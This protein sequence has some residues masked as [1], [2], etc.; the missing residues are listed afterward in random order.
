[1]SSSSATFNYFYF[2][3]NF[4]LFNFNFTFKFPHEQSK[5]FPHTPSRTHA[6][7]PTNI[8]IFDTISTPLRSQRLFS[9]RTLRTSP[10]RFCNK[11]SG[12]LASC[13]R[14][15]I[16]DHHSHGRD[17][18]FVTNSFLAPLTKGQVSEA[19]GITDFPSS[20]SILQL[21]IQIATPP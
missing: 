9:R 6:L 3:Y 4:W 5:C 20:S 11:I 15:Q 19:N 8:F 12:T 2:S 10:D 13:T 14:T 16:I 1:M 21:L 17:T 18:F 7:V